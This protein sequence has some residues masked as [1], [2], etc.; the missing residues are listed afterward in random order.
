MRT[1]NSS[2]SKVCICTCI[3]HKNHYLPFVFSAT[4]CWNRF[5]WSPDMVLES[6]RSV[7]EGPGSIT[8]KRVTSVL[9][10]HPVD[11]SSHPMTSSNSYVTAMKKKESH[12]ILFLLFCDLMLGISIYTCQNIN[13]FRIIHANLLIVFVLFLILRVKVPIP[14]I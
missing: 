9:N 8:H 11:T 5:L 7:F 1:V 12:S 13:T 4:S 3:P 10:T 2:S 14:F 6:L